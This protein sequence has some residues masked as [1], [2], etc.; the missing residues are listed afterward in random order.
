MAATKAPT[1]LSTSRKN[2]TFTFTWKIADKDYGA[3]QQLQYRTNQTGAGKWINV[4]IGHATISKSVT[5]DEDLFYPYQEDR[6]KHVTFRVRGKRK[7]YDET[8]YK[9][10]T[11]Y[12]PDWS[13]WASKTYSVLEPSRPSL[14][15]E[16]TNSN[17]TVFSWETEDKEKSNKILTNVQYQ[18]MLVKDCKETDGSKFKWHSAKPGWDSGTTGA[19][20]SK[21]CEEDT[22]ILTDASWTRWIRV[23]SRGPR[24]ASAWRYGK[25]V[26]ATPYKAVISSAKATVKSSAT[27]VTVKWTVASN[28]AHPID[29]TTVEYLMAVPGTG[30]SVPAGASWTEGNVSDD[31]AG[32]DA[33]KFTIGSALDANQ[34][35]WVRVVTKHD[36]NEQYSTPKLVLCGKLTAPTDL[37][38]TDIDDTTYRATVSATNGS[39]VPDSRLAV[40]FAKKGWS[41]PIVLG[42]I[43]HGDSSVT[44]QCPSWSRRL[45]IPGQSIAHFEE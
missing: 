14:E 29:S 32:K 43:A 28:A 4:T 6:L 26:Y 8:R 21:T 39:S 20:G 27:T 40:A 36:A 22:T 15:A 13:A 24:D 16:L 23:R 44:V 11:H 33:A 34:C 41:K 9:D 2:L 19:N 3:G 10:T 17:T 1:G 31:T 35:L 45:R 37:S 5:L 25:H 38:V 7:P 30:L 12:E 18:T 42:I